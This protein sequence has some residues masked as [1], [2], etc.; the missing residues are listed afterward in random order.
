MKSSS[1]RALKLSLSFLFVSAFQ[2]TASYAS[3]IDPKLESWISETESAANPNQFADAETPKQEVIVYLKMP[4]YHDHSGLAPAQALVEETTFTRSFLRERSKELITMLP[5]QENRVDY[6]WS[7]NAMIVQVDRTALKK[8]RRDP[9]V[10]GI[11]YNRIVSLDEPKN[12]QGGHHENKANESKMTY[13]LQAIHADAAWNQGI[14]GEGVVIGVID[15]GVDETHPDLKGKILLKKDFTKENNNLDGDGHGTHVCGTIVGGDASGTQI[16]VAPGAK[17]IMAKAL[18]SKGEATLGTLLKA[19]EWMLD[20]DGDPSTNDAPRLVSNS[21]GTSIQFIYGFR[22]VIRSWRRFG[23]FPNFAAGN[24]GPI[25]LSVNAPGSYPFAFAVGAIDEDSNITSFSSRGP[26][27]WWKGWHP[28]LV[29]K[30]EIAAPGLY[31]KSSIP[32]GQW[33]TMSGTSM[34]TPHIAGVAALAFQ[35]NPNL[36]TEALMEILETTGLDRSNKGGDNRYGHGV[37]QVDKVI[38]RA[39]A[40]QVSAPSSFQDKDPSQWEWDTP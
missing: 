40:W 20:P 37:V 5:L 8:L 33:D 10:E 18:D 32:N 31:V 17:I 4:S 25:Y 7:S 38:E 19:M 22:N 36:T 13:G 12:L 15:T 2:M 35:A 16:G 30:P 29:R 27:I 1:C 24:S 14:T 26:T 23:I 28:I 3:F 6:L 11:I 39:K 21:W 34:A 9:N